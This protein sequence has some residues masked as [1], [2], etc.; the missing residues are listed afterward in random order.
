MI[1]RMNGKFYLFVNMDVGK[2][3]AAW[4]FSVVYSTPEFII[5]GMDVPPIAV[6]F[7]RGKTHPELRRYIDAWLTLGVTM[8][9]DLSFKKVRSVFAHKFTS[10]LEKGAFHWSSKRFSN[11]RY[12]TEMHRICRLGGP[13]AVVGGIRSMVDD[14]LTRMDLAAALL[15]VVG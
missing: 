11:D 12:G 13:D 9:T 7:R 1:E 5:N 3:P 14:E 2:F 4:G 6:L 15:G 10:Y 8:S